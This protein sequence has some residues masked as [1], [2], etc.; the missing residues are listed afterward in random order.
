MFLATVSK[1]RQLL[2]TRYLNEVRRGELVQGL[3]EVNELY[4]QLSPGFTVLVDLTQLTEIDPECATE[5][6]ALMESF[7]GAGVGRVVR[8]IPDDS[9]DIGFNIMGVFHYPKGLPVMNCQNFQEAARF[10]EA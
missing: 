7:V 6:G 8:V 3:T 9:K 1:S 2:V 5:V 10:L 4:S